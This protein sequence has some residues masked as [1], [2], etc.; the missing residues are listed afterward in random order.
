M[1]VGQPGSGTPKICKV[2][3]RSYL[4]LAV[5]DRPMAVTES[6]QGVLGQPDFRTHKLRENRRVSRGVLH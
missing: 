4:P 1:T 3:T 2:A 5:A 6:W